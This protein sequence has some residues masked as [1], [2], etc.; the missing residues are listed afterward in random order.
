VVWCTRDKTA[1]AE[2]EI[3]YRD[4]TSPS[5][6]VRFPLVDERGAAWRSKLDARLEG[7]R[8]ALVI[9]TTT[10]WTLPANLAIVAH[11]ALTYVA[12]PNPR[13]PG[14]YLIVAQKLAESVAAAIG[15]G[16]LGRAIEIAPHEMAAL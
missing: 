6:Y 3:E 10:P 1:L 15:G 4:H 11:P 7:K 12:F 2:F 9:W 14:E 5:V 8:L 13:D 16:D